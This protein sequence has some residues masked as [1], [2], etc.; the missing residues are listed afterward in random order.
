MKNFK[1]FLGIFLVFSMLIVTLAGCNSKSNEPGDTPSVETEVETSSETSGEAVAVDTDAFS[2]SDGIDANGFWEGVRALDYVEIFNY[3][4]MQIPNDV[5]YV[6]DDDIQ[7]EI[8]RI[9]A[10]Y[11]SSGQVTDRAVVDGDKVNIDYVGSIDGV[12]FSG[13][14][15]GG[16]GTDVTAGSLGYIDDFLVQIIGHMPGETFNVEVTFPEDYGV[17]D[18]NGKDAVFVTT[19]NHIV[20]VTLPEMTDEFVAE[21][22]SDEYGWTSVGEMKD[23]ARTNLQKAAIQKYINE[24]FSNE[25][26]V[27][28]VPEKMTEYQEQAMLSYYKESAA[29]YSMEL[30]EFLA[31]AAGVASVD[32]LIEVNRDNTAAAVTFY[33]VI[34]A[35]AED[36][37]ISVSE[38]DLGDYFA[39]YVGTSDYS[40]FEE[41]FGLPYLKQVVLC[42]KVIDYVAENSVQL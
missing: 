12:E 26:T 27:Q 30:D 23:G 42:Q 24:Y 35:V 41:Q 36:A 19:I 28:S 32:E 13:G 14:S 15:T 25:V 39:E 10:N 7:N 4:E 17:D 1:T 3:R 16:A 20:E 38:A 33:L 9:H 21:N 40:S 2:Y 37:G 5:H 31:S 34:Q 18:L 6:S 22:L 8:D 11:S 29:Y